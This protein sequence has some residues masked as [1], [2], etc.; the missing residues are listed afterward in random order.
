[1]ETTKYQNEIL[2]KLQ[3]QAKFWA[4]SSQKFVPDTLLENID[5]MN[6][7]ELEDTS[8]GIIELDDKGRVIFFNNTES[9][10]TGVSKEEAVGK[11]FFT[12][13]APCTNN[14]IFKGT[15]ENG[16]QKN[17][18]NH[19]FPYTFTYRMAPTHVKVH[20]YRTKQRRNFIFILRR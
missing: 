5:F 1:M 6:K 14:F 12:E 8:F 11:N 7:S 16:V 18:L 20:L 19:L 10:L 17:E 9:K 3:K 4:D 13:V 15:F 2:E